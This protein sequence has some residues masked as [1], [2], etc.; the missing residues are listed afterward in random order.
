MPT[1][2]YTY[3]VEFTETTVWGRERVRRHAEKAEAWIVGEPPGGGRCWFLLVDGRLHQ[4]GGSGVFGRKD[5]ISASEAY[6]DYPYLSDNPGPNETR[7]TRRMWYM[8]RYHDP[9]DEL[10]EIMAERIA[11]VERYGA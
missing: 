2:Q 6:P 3:H 1:S 4:H 9:V 8:R 11:H 7:E 10:V 5:L